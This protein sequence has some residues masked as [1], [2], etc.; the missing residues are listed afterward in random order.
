MTDKEI[1]K[2]ILIVEDEKPIAEIL[3]YGLT[4][5]GFAVQWAGTGGE[6][7][8]QVGTFAPSLV[9]LDWMLPDVSGVDLCRMIT[10][11]YNIPI[12][13]LTARG[14]IED[15]LYGLET[16]ADD[17]ITKPFDLREV[18]ARVKSILRRFE[19]AGGGR[20][21]TETAREE[22]P[23]PLQAGGCLRILEREWVVEQGGRRI[24][25]TPKEFELLCYL[26]K[27]PRQVFTRAML[28]EQIWGYDFE[29]DTR[30]VDIH[31]Q[32]LRKKLGPDVGLKTV[33]GVGYKYEPEE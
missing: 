18:T 8:K 15:K 2:K 30:T 11:K 22:E 19:K 24:D 1:Q 12:V 27:H 14:S 4:K 31:V 21:K 17:Y 28:L 32:R 9:L 25:L 13:M 3:S 16:G 26:V 29:G 7:W 5:E 6:G 23:C 33:F 20:D 10:E